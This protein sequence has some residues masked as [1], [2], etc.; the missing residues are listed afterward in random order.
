MRGISV[1]LSKQKCPLGLLE[2]PDTEKLNCL[3]HFIVEAKD[4]EPYV[5]YMDLCYPSS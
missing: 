4:G 3:S 1:L 2:N 5:P